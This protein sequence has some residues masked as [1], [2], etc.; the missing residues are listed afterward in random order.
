MAVSTPK[1][2]EIRARL[3]KI[4]VFGLLGTRVEPA[5]RVYSGPGLHPWTPAPGIAG[6]P[7][8]GGIDVTKPRRFIGFGSIDVNKPYNLIGFVGI[9]VTK[10]YKFTG[11]GGI[12]VTKPYKIYRVYRPYMSPNPIDL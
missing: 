3:L 12:D 7:G 6:T 2:D 9:D 5:S 10:P 4:T 1:I 11:F 8:F